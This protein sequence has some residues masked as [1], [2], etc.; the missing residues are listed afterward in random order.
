MIREDF[1]LD[2]YKNED[3]KV[4]KGKMVISEKETRDYHKDGGES[5]PLK[6]MKAECFNK[7]GCIYYEKKFDFERLI[8]EVK[9]DNLLGIIIF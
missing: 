7:W 3:K 1:C 9:E 2:C 4:E 6:V 8:S 5:I